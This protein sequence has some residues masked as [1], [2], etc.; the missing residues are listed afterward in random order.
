VEKA[1]EI[2]QEDTEMIKDF[3]PIDYLKNVKK[4]YGLAT[5]LE[6][7]D[8]LKNSISRQ[9]NVAESQNAF[10][11]SVLE[12]GRKLDKA[13]SNRDDYGEL[14]LQYIDEMSEIVKNNSAYL[15][16]ADKKII[17][18]LDRERRTVMG[19]FSVLNAIEKLQKE[20]SLDSD[21]ARV[22]LDNALNL[23]Q[24][25]IISENPKTISNA[26]S[27]LNKA[28]TEERAFESKKSQRISS[29]RSSL[30]RTTKAKLTPTVKS[31]SSKLGTLEKRT[32]NLASEYNPGGK[33]ELSMKPDQYFQSFSLERDANVKAYKDEVGKELATLIK[34][35]GL[36]AVDKKDRDTVN[37]L[38]NLARKG[39][40]EASDELYLMLKDLDTDMNFYG[41]KQK[42]TNAKNI[43][44]QY[45]NLYK[46][47]YDADVEATQR[48]GTDYGYGQVTKAGSGAGNAATDESLDWMNF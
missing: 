23:A 17:D 16:Q 46:I 1:G 41:I 42:D 25:G 31:I 5:V 43:Y 48:F 22:H 4:D 47:L 45:L 7:L 32:K 37:E 9:K 15:T 44:K 33:F 10:S 8:K 20:Q 30:E 38:A 29:E 24:D 26:F 11:N 27:S 3:N 35:S 28:I 19:G 6:G 18:D 21:A 2:I 39:D 12:Y 13:K 40:F 34:S 14:S 36:D